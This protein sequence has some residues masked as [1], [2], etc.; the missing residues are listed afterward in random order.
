MWSNKGTDPMTWGNHRLIAEG[1]GV[2]PE[3]VQFADTNG[4]GNLDYVVVSRVNGRSRSWHNLGFI[5][6]DKVNGA[7]RWN[8]PLSFADGTGPGFAIR[9]A[10]VRHS[11]VWLLL[12]EDCFF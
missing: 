11:F 6:G 12:L 2:I 10:E 4:D 9:I 3:E 7:I 5:D 1:P 8:T